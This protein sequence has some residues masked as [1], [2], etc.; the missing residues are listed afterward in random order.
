MDP[1]T[2]VSNKADLL[3]ENQEKNTPLLARKS[4]IAFICHKWTHVCLIVSI[5]V[6]LLF[7]QLLNK[8][9]EDDILFTLYSLYKNMTLKKEEEEELQ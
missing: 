2:F 8:L 9:T 1:L 3:N 4:R 5:L 6:I 7:S